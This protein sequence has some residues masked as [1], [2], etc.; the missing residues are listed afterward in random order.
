MERYVSCTFTHLVEVRPFVDAKRLES[1]DEAAEFRLLAKCQWETY[2]EVEARQ[3]W[4]RASKKVAHEVRH[5][6]DA[7]RRLD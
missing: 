7:L 2:R 5:R 4:L 6:A 1:F 3:R